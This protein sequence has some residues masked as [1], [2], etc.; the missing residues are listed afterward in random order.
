[1]SIQRQARPPPPVVPPMPAPPLWAPSDAFPPPVSL[2]PVVVLPPRP[3]PPLPVDEPVVVPL[4]R[5]VEDLRPVV[6]APSIELLPLV[7]A[8]SNSSLSLLPDRMFSDQSLIWSLRL[9]I[10]SLMVLRR[11]HRNTPAP[12]AT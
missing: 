5:P 3:R 1:M 2:M 6:L 4:A 8:V 12:T 7:S 9:L 11:D 10:C